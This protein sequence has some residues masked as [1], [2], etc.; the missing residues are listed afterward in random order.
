MLTS[1]Q[2]H[3]ISACLWFIFTAPIAAGGTVYQ[4]VDTEGHTHLSDTVPAGQP[5]TVIELHPI[6]AGKK[7]GLRP[8]ERAALQAIEQR[9]A[10]QHR[11]AE[12][13]RHKQRQHRSRSRRDCT[14]HRKALR[15]SQDHDSSKS[16]ARYLR[17]HC[18]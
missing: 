12:I 9:Q 10:Q 4:W 16:H 6:S 5:A 14:A 13:D 15:L 8:G 7:S 1:H 11:V 3:R 17:E 2:L 18:W